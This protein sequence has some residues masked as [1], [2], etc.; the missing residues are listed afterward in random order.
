MNSPDFPGQASATHAS[1]AIPPSENPRIAF[2]HL[3]DVPIA[4]RTMVGVLQRAF[5][6]AQLVRID[7]KDRIKQNKRA[8]LTNLFF[9]LKEYWKELLLRQRRPWN[10]FFTT[11]YLFKHIKKLAA[12][13]VGENDF[14]FTFQMQSMFDASVSGTPHFVYTDHT[15]LVNLTYPHFDRATLPT[16][17]WL[18]LEKSIYAN[19]TM[20]FVRSSH[21]LRSLIEQY[22]CPPERTACVYAGSN[23]TI[24][25]SIPTKRDS[26][27]KS[28]L[29]VGIDWERKG[30]PELIEA[31][32]RVLVHHP[33]ATLTIVGCQPECDLPNCQVVGLVPVAEVARYYRNAS[34]F[35]LPTKVEPFGI[36]FVEALHYG[37]P[38]VAT[39]IGALPDLVSEGNGRLVP[40]GEVDA[41]A[42]ALIELLSDP[43]ALA[44]L[45]E[46]SRR[47]AL[48][49]YNWES[50]GRR[51]RQEISHW[52]DV[53]TP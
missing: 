52:V 37:L 8:V 24:D 39:R 43:E 2:F 6:E 50:V 46:E 31:F 17:K 11:T 21:V 32:K 9:M 33:N 40:P 10:C 45:G 28:I 38:I 16:P 42:T 4:N 1:G 47:L 29:F 36:V 15:F 12:Q 48:E 44:L 7:V 34:I 14:A 20:T 41:L 49:R 35:C 23:T 13:I 30:G 25:D 22:G 3:G 18:A 53:D 5:P 27:R 26:A 51:M 19:A